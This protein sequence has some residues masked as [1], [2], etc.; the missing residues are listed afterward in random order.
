VDITRFRPQVAGT[1]LW[2]ITPKILEGLCR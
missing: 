2:S 1:L